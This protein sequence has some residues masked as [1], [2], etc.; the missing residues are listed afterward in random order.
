MTC[1]VVVQIEAVRERDMEDPAVR[2]PCEG[3]SYLGKG[4]ERCRV[5]RARAVDLGL[6]DCM[7]GYIY[8]EGVR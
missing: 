2:T 5:M 6:P 3:C 7:L 4:A 1:V 8:V